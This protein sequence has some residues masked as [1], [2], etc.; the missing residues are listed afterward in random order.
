L[1][2]T[3][4]T[5]TPEPGAS[6]GAVQEA[7]QGTQADGDDAPQDQQISLVDGVL[8]G[9]EDEEA[10]HEVRA[11]ALKLELGGDATDGD[12][13]AKKAETKWSTKGVG[14]LL[15]LKHKTTG[16]V[17]MLLRAAPGG[18]IALN[19]LVLP[20]FTYKP[21]P[22]GG[23][24]VKITTA[25]DSGKGLETWMLQVKT[26]ELAQ[27]LADALEANKSANEKKE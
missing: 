1:A 17:R 24:Y 10:V 14:P 23:K 2:T 11:K 9:Q 16:K 13:P 22:N 7:N 5:G 15:L 21:E 25:N 6:A 27:S 26:K 19:K 12:S 20:N 3:P 8:P 4:A 18:H